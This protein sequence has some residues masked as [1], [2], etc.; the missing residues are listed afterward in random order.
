M[1]PQPP[2]SPLSTSPVS[3]QNQVQRNEPADFM[4]ISA[5]VVSLSTSCKNELASL[6]SSMVYFEFRFRFL[7]LEARSQ[8]YFV[9]LSIATSSSSVVLIVDVDI[10]G[11]LVIP[12]KPALAF[13]SPKSAS[14]FFFVV[15][16]FL[17][18]QLFSTVL[19]LLCFRVL[20]AWH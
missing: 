16:T 7:K 12:S 15:S 18:L 2:T 9:V 13:Y 17:F 20:A 5:M 14:L 1:F 8:V 10:E 19:C 6:V 11:R 4:K 3:Y